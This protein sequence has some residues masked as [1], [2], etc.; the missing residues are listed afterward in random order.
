MMMLSRVSMVVGLLSIGACAPTVKSAAREASTAAV[1]QSV[2]ELSKDETKSKVQEATED[3]RI[4]EAT[5]KLSEQIAEGVV[6]SLAAPGTREQ[7]NSVAASA[8]RAASRE[9]IRSLGSAEAQTAFASLASTA[10]EQALTRLGSHMQNDFRPAFEDALRKDISNGIADGLAAPNLQKS[11]TKSAELAAYGA[12]TGANHGFTTAWQDAK[13][14]PLADLR[15]LSM[16]GGTWLMLLAM[17]AGGVA[18][19]VVCAVLLLM[20]R[21]RRARVEVARL[22]SATL[23][24][25]TA[26]HEGRDRAETDELLATVRDSLQHGA[27]D[28]VVGSRGA[29]WSPPA[30][31]H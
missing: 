20:S 16:G 29:W 5:A 23:L 2:T 9:M 7:L 8:A 10:S 18:L 21:D 13:G 25:A 4:A 3:P 24:L 26:M 14:G 27:R 30:H 17:L 1:D 22:E 28:H 19:A 31:R 15:T 12:V 6:R 11:L